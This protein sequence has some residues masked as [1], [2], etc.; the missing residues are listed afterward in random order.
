MSPCDG[1]CGMDQLLI[2]DLRLCVLLPLS[3]V[4]STTVTIP[5]FW[6][7]ATGLIE[8]GEEQEGGSEGG[9]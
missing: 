8:Q 2:C 6:P 3:I 4:A 1:C 7:Q 9:S 5:W